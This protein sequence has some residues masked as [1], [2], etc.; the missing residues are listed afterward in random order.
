MA[1]GQYIPKKGRAS[2]IWRPAE[3][4]VSRVMKVMGN[5]ASYV[6]K[7]A[8]AVAPCH[9]RELDRVSPTFFLARD[10]PGGGA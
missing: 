1:K 3:Q 7:P 8:D 6:R 2:L 10:A 4:K 5:P 9:A